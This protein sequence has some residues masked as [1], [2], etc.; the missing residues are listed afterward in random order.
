MTGV[1]TGEGTD[2]HTITHKTTAV[3]DGDITEI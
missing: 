2:E 1:L 3:Q